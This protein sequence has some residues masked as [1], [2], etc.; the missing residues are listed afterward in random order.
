MHFMICLF[1]YQNT[2]QTPSGTPN[3]RFTRRLYSVHAARP[4]RAYGALEGPTMLPHRP[5]SALS[6]KLCK[7]RAAEFILSMLFWALHNSPCHTKRR[8]HSVCSVLKTCQR[9]VRS[10]RNTPKILNLPVKRVHNILAASLQ[11]PHDVPTASLQRPWRFYG[12]QA[13]AAAWSR[14]AHSA[15]TA[16][17]RR[18]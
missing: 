2:L 14:R 8:C 9:D 12:A 16:F 3:T 4:Q 10:P 1:Y 18:L 17:S 6:N 15:P 7:H 5:Y 11:R 13:V